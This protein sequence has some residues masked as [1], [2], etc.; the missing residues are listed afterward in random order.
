[1]IGVQDQAHIEIPGR[2]RIGSLTIKE[3]EEIGGVPQ[4]FFRLQWGAVFPNAIPGGHN[5]GHL[6]NQPNR[7][8]EI[9]LLPLG[10]GSWVMIREHGD[11]GLK[12]IHGMGGFGSFLEG[13]NDGFGNFPLPGEG[14][15]EGF[16][17]VNGGEIPKEQEV[18]DFF[19]GRMP[20]EFQNI[21]APVNQYPLFAVDRADHGIR[22]GNASESNVFGL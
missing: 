14:L 16:E 10:P 7:L 19:K 21:I 12:H 2:F 3:I 9:R 4:G 17:L 6:C 20:C 15:L 13:A 8:C 5:G 18:S 1:M 22:N 11:R